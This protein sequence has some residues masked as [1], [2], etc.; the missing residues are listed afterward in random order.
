MLLISMQFDTQRK[1]DSHMNLRSWRSCFEDLR[2]AMRLLRANPQVRLM[3]IN[4][5][6][7]ADVL[8]AE[9]FS[10][11]D[12]EDADREKLA[13]KLEAFSKDGSVQIYGSLIG[14][15]EQLRTEYTKSLQHIDP[16]TREY[17]VRLQ[18]EKSLIELAKEVRWYY[19][20]VEDF[21]SAA[22]AAMTVVEH[23][24]YKHDTM[25]NA[26]HLAHAHKKQFGNFADLHPGCLGS[27]TKLDADKRSPE[28]CHPASFV[29]KPEP[30]V[31]LVDSA[32]EMRQLCKFLYKHGDERSK[33]RTMLCHIY[34]HAI[35]DRFYEARDFLLMSHLQDSIAHSDIST[36]ILFN[37][38]MAQLGLCAFRNG[39][40]HESHS[41]L[42]EIQSQG[43][44]KE[45]L[46]QGIQRYSDKYSEKNTEQENAE[47]RRQTPYHMHI[48]LEL[49]ECVYL[50]CAML[51]EVQP[52]QKRN[53]TPHPTCVSPMS[54][55]QACFAYRL[56]CTKKPGKT[57]SLFSLRH[58]CPQIHPPSPPAS[59]PPASSP[60]LPPLPSRLSRFQTW[61][62]KPVMDAVV[63]SAKCSADTWTTMT[64]NRSRA[65]LRIPV[66]TS[67]RRRSASERVTGR[68]AAP[69]C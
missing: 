32:N 35:H 10:G 66:T 37:R 36:Q 62:W 15:M 29:G 65:P 1:I 25:A 8:M 47:R 44:V 2:T 40:V 46:A 21:E 3:G 69:C 5:E 38:M 23:I 18:D 22:T 57:E 12:A 56:C 28:T 48:N 51:L 11:K 58:F 59:S 4:S 63:L 13:K 6:D 24:Y 27:S 9:E 49:L 61:P 67:W 43:R 26:V 16:H 20:L 54:P 33:I 64:A 39:M 60:P 52:E 30:D 68:S 42:M 41:C 45:L 17:I 19:E 53:K 14:L 34:H 7:L 55:Y 50:I 31:E